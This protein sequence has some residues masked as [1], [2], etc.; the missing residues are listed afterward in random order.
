MYVPSIYLI[1]GEAC[2]G[3]PPAAARRC[4][5]GREDGGGAGGGARIDV[6]ALLGPPFDTHIDSLRSDKTIALVK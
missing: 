4:A 3:A 1:S 6:F 5:V 2:T